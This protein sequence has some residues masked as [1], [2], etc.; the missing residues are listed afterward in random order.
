MRAL[1]TIPYIFVAC[2]SMGFV[3]FT[4]MSVVVLHDI[5]ESRGQAIGAINALANVPISN[6]GKIPVK[7]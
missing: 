5:A 1:K 4:T 2:L 3:S 7:I 6:L